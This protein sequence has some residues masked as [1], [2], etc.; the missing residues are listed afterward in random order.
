MAAISYACSRLQ[1][2]EADGPTKVLMTPATALD[3]NPGER[4]ETRA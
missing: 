1:R 3:P 2:F 4:E